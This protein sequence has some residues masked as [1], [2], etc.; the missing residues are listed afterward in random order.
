MKNTGITLISVIITIIVIII[1]AGVAIYNGYGTPE[2]A[3][4]TN[5]TD[6][7]DNIRLEI[8]TIRAN[9][10]ADYRDKERGFTLVTI[11]NAPE[12]FVS[13]SDV[14]GEIKGYL[15]DMEKLSKRIHF[16]QGTPAN[17]NVVVFDE[18]DVLVY[19]KNGTIYYTKG[20][21]YKDRLFYNATTS[22]KVE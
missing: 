13:A 20:Y 5:Y 9:N 16:G 7:I 6:I 4:F 8:G 14:S 22:K 1:L 21:W 11:E 3:S 2:T 19:D 10:F 12:D 18:D 17:D 15:I